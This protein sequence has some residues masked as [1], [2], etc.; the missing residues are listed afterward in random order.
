M[1]VGMNP[2]S[3]EGVA[4]MFEK[5]LSSDSE[6]KDKFSRVGVV[7]FI[8]SESGHI[9]VLKENQEERTTQKK[10]GELS[11]VCETANPGENWAQTVVRGIEE[12]L[13]IAPELQERLFMVPT[14]ECFLGETLFV[15]SVLARVVV[16]DFVGSPDL[17]VPGTNLGEMTVV[18]W[19]KPDVVLANYSLRQGVRKVLG[20]CLDN[21]LLK[22]PGE[23]INFSLWQLT[24]EMKT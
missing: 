15:E 8:R 19:E 22:R 14:G 12:E 1:I 20:E 6:I 21:G 17:F 3:Q 16:V 23:L 7:V 2:Y 4:F 24:G 9:L 5:N 13:G 10:M 11:V 18:G